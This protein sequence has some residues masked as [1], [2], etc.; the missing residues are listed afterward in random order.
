MGDKIVGPYWGDTLNDNR[1]HLIEICNQFSLC[2][3]N[4]FFQHQDIHKKTWFQPRRNLS[5]I[6]DC[7]VVKQ[8]TKTKI[9]GTRV[10]RGVDSGS[11]HYLLRSAVLFKYVN[12][13]VEDHRRENSIPNRMFLMNVSFR[14]L[15]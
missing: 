12:Y 9:V 4:G 10:Y 3:K 11:D 13:V 6:I 7:I 2:I 5:S 1:E 14:M 15:Q 8:Q